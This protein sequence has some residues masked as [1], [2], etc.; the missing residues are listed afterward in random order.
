M[1]AAFLFPGFK[2]PHEGRG[3]WEAGVEL[4][5]L[6]RSRLGSSVEAIGGRVSLGDADALECL[7]VPVVQRLTL[8]A[9]L[10]PQGKALEAVRAIREGVSQ[11]FRSGREA[12]LGRRDSH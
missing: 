8:L 11:P 6:P 1:P 10:G 2:C 9:A 4:P 12:G 7:V 3:C 5:G